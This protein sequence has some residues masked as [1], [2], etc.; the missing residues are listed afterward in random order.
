MRRARQL[1]G[2]FEQN[3]L[4][5]IEG[6]AINLFYRTLFVPSPFES[7]RLIKNGL[8]FFDGHIVKTLNI[9][10]PIGKIMSPHI[11]IHTRLRGCLARRLR[12]QA[13]LFS[14]PK[15]LFV[16]FFLVSSIILFTPLRKHFVYSFP[17][18]IQRITGYY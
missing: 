3:Y 7:I 4:Y 9:K 2:N 1:H 6:R 5:M 13:A 16:S 10:L 11:N 18:D 14:P 17:I 12:G 15:F 8:L